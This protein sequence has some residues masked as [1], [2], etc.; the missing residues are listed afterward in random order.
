MYMPLPPTPAMHFMTYHPFQ[1]VIT[2]E[3]PFF[4]LHLLICNLTPAPSKDT[5]W[6]VQ[7]Q[8]M[9]PCLVQ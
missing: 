3:P 9:I 2:N 5:F 6:E 4:N 8:N 1:Q 7:L